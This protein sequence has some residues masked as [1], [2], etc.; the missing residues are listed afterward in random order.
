MRKTRSAILAFDPE[1]STLE[2]LQRS[3][4]DFQLRLIEL[5]DVIYETWF[6]R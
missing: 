3:I 5:N 6:L 1:D 4:D 2:E